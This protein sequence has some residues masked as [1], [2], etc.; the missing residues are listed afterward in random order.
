MQEIKILK[1]QASWC[2]PC[3]ALS[4][5]IK[6]SGTQVPVEE[7]DID[8]DPTLAAKHRVRAVPTCVILKDGQ[9]VGRSTGMMTAAAW[10]KFVE[11]ATE[12]L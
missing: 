2:Q 5:V 12:D 9:E 11:D 6:S 8:N 3:K 4:N 10:K 1:F 7:I